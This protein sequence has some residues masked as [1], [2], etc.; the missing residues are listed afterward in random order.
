MTKMKRALV[1]LPMI[2]L[3]CI[4]IW[5]V[6][7]YKKPHTGAGNKTTD[8]QIDAVAL[9]NDFAKNEALSIIT[10]YNHLLSN[11]VQSVKVYNSISG[12]VYFETGGHVFELVFS[13]SQG[14][15]EP[16]YLA[17]TTDS[18]GKGGYTLS[19]T[20]PGF[21]ILKNDLIFL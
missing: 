6:Y 12:G 11:Q 14:M 10:K 2:I 5:A 7:E 20:F 1:T 15:I 17:K 16:Y 8:I 9:Y 18:W 19:S 21:L 3:L 13:N 4:A